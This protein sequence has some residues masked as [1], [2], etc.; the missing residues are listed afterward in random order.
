MG[1]VELDDVVS[2]SPRKANTFSFFPDSS[3]KMHIAAPIVAI[4]VGIIVC[5]LTLIVLCICTLRC[6]TMIQRADPLSTQENHDIEATS[7]SHR[8]YIRTI[9]NYTHI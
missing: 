8:E 5:L 7:P 1:K 4:I 6:S 3:K 9:E 2:L